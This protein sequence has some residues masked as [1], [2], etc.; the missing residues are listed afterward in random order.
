MAI[1]LLFLIYYYYCSIFLFKK[2][3]FSSQGGDYCID[4]RFYGNVARFINHSCEPNLVSIRVFIEHQDANF[5]RIA[6]FTMRDV[7]ALEELW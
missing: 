6:F 3:C 1:V 5:P 2:L 4:G 7:D